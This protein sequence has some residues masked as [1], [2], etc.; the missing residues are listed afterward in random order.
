MLG[1]SNLVS[2]ITCWQI[3]RRDANLVCLLTLSRADLTEEQQLALAE[4]ARLAAEDEAHRART[5]TKQPAVG[6]AAAKGKSTRK[7]RKAAG[8]LLMGA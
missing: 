8:D 5:G 2:S 6:P 1:I 4:V 3:A 7:K